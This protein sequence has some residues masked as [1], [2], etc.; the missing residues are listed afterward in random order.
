MRPAP[1]PTMLRPAAA[2]ALAIAAGAAPLL[3]APEPIRVAA[4]WSFLAVGPGLALIG[5][6]GL[7]GPLTISLFAVALSLTVD[8]LVACLLL[9]AGAWSPSRSLDLLILLSLTASWLGLWRL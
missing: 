2:A 1:R 3:P 4:T 5:A 9:Y 8:A 6:S 7:G